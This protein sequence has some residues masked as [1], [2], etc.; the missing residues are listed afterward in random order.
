VLL[1]RALATEAPVILLDEPAASLD[2][3]HG[4]RL[5]RLLGRL[6]ESGRAILC[7]LHALDDARTYGDRVLLLHE[8]RLVAQGPAAEVVTPHRVRSVYCV[9]LLENQALG[10]RLMDPGGAGRQGPVRR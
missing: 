6:A 3:A 1:A 5:F 9:E 4:L 10:F 7:V 8:G 2:V